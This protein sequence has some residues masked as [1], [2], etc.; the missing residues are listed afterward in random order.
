MQLSVSTLLVF[1]G[2]GLAGLYFLGAM[3]VRELAVQAVLRQCR[4]DGFQLLDQSVHI[5][6][7]SLSRDTGG[8]WRVWRQYRFDYSYDGVQRQRG[9]VI[10]L[11]KQLQAVV[12]PEEQPTLH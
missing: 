6:R 9:F 1:I 10:M 8:R 7:V 11:G 4:V 3:R 2:G 12:V 5:R